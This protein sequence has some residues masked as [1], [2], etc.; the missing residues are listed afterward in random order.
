MPPSHA[1]P[2]RKRGK[3]DPGLNQSQ[4]PPSQ[5]RA[6]ERLQT[7]W[8][9]QDGGGPGPLRRRHRVAPWEAVEQHD[10]QPRPVGRQQSQPLD[11]AGREVADIPDERAGCFI[12]AWSAELPVDHSVA[13]DREQV[14]ESFQII[15]PGCGH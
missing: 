3:H 8:P 10:K 5:K 13:G 15:G 1:S 7:D 9:A 12:E 14:A 2:T 4:G 6:G 11:F